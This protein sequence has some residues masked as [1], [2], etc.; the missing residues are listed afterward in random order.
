MEVGSAPALAPK[1]T[2][3]RAQPRAAAHATSPAFSHAAGA[4]AARAG[5]RGFENSECFLWAE[6]PHRPLILTRA[7]RGVPTPGAGCSPPPALGRGALRASEARGVRF[8]GVAVR[9][10]AAR[11]MRGRAKAVSP[12]LQTRNF[13]EGWVE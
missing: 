5:A 3:P 4:C 9:L 6:D 7:G 8:G 12:I 1:H 2:R 13:H 10:R 11:G